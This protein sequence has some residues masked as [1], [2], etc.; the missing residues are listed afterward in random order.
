VGELDAEQMF[1]LRSRGV[2]EAEARAILIRAFLN[3]AL[4]AV[5]HEATR[6]AMEAGID[7]WWRKEA[8]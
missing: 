2:P 1:Y 5:T 7:A 4:Q 6:A 3:E 8:A